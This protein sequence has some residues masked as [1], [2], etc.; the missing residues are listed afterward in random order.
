M[1]L[2]SS[3]PLGSVSKRHNVGE[4]DKGQHDNA[5]SANA[6]DGSTAQQ[7]GHVVRRAANGGAEGEHEDGE[8]EEQGSSE[9]VA[10]GG[11]KGHGDGIGE[12]IRGADPEGLR[13]GAVE[14]DD[15]GLGSADVS[16]SLRGPRVGRWTVT[17]LSCEGGRGVCVLGLA[18]IQRSHNDAGVESHHEGDDR[19]GGH[20][21]ELVSGWRPAGGSVVFFPSRLHIQRS[22]FDTAGISLLR[23]LVVGGSRAQTSEDSHCAKCW[24][25]SSQS[26]EEIMRALRATGRIWRTMGVWAAVP[27]WSWEG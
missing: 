20:D 12:E 2:H 11:E 25:R 16:T 6:L 27:A 5:A 23:L 15:D 13:G 9:G 17:V 24:K 1:H 7:R 22:V 3:V 8:D 26:A 19:Q 14:V 18:H 4:D 21:E 10:E